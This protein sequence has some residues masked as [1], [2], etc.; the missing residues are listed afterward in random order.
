MLSNSV[1]KIYSESI[2]IFI[3]PGTIAVGTG[4]V[5]IKDGCSGGGIGYRGFLACDKLVKRFLFLTRDGSMSRRSIMNGCL[6]NVTFDGGRSR[7]NI[8]KEFKKR[9][10]FSGK[11]CFVRYLYYD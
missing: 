6:K 11:M 8:P 4:R 3:R 2:I 10:C 9:H 7:F 5:Y 1:R